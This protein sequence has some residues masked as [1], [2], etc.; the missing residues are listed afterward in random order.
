MIAPYYQAFRIMIYF[1]LIVNLTL[2]DCDLVI[3]RWTSSFSKTRII[4]WERWRRHVS[5]QFKLSVSWK[6]V[7]N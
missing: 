1:A 4:H 7:Y 3:E 6:Q 2:I 5:K